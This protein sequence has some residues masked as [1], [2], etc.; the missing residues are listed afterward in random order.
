MTTAPVATMPGVERQSPPWSRRLWPWVAGLA[1][2]FV[3]V[4]ELYLERLF[5]IVTG[6]SGDNFFE[7]LISAPSSK[8]NPDWSHALV[9]PFISAFFIYTKRDEI[10][11]ERPRLYFPGL[12]IL[13][14][15]LFGY[16]FWVTPG[17][18]DMMQG[19]SM[20]VGLFGL[21]LFLLG[22]AVMRH[23]WFPILYLV[24]AVKVAD[25]LWEQIAFEL[26]QIAATGAGIALEFCTL[27]FDFDVT[28]EGSQIHLRFMQNGAPVNAPLNVA[29]AC[30]GLRSL[31]AFVALGV[32]MAF[33][34]ERPWWQRLVM[35]LAAVPI[36][37]GV[38]VGRVT[39]LG[40]LYLVN[41]EYARGDFHTMIGLFMLIPAAGLFYV[42]GWVLDRIFVREEG[43]TDDGSRRP[44][45]A[46]GNPAA[47]AAPVASGEAD[48]KA[49]VAGAAVMLA[50][51]VAATLLAA[52]VYRLMLT[53]PVPALPPGGM[54]ALASNMLIKLGWL[55]VPTAA[56]ATG[57]ALGAWV[58]TRALRQKHAHALVLGAAL[59]AGVYATMF[60]YQ[61]VAAARSGEVFIKQ[62]VPLRNPLMLIPAEVGAWKLHREDPPLPADILQELG[63]DKYISRIYEDTGWPAG[64]PGGLV[65]LHVAYYTGTMDAVPHVPERCFVG[66]GAEPL[67]KDLTTL[68]LSGDYRPDPEVEGGSLHPVKLTRGGKRQPDARLASTSIDATR[69]TFGDPG[70][71]R[72]ENVIYF[73]AANGKFLPTPDHVRFAGFDPK[74]KYQYYCKVEVQ[75]FG[76]SDKEL[77]SQRA[78]SLLS[79]LLPEIMACLPDWVD[80]TAGRWPEGAAAPAE[81]R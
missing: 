20:I 68:S 46:A 72:S 73:F 63:T 53:L 71:M 48:T 25:R 29:E 1:G 77:A 24:F 52:V 69:F 14:A 18:N 31:M 78:A 26:Q 41:P 47:A 43:G 30:S 81:A 74:D 4:H 33:L 23:L 27:I 79:D 62:A 15:G 45:G 55:L 61:G 40:L 50:A 59:V 36:A 10:A 44:N 54:V 80:V 39:V 35:I 9:I 7:L 12:A 11:A 8:L 34:W 38:N 58:L 16:L 37:V 32:A 42:I 5:R 6:A 65:R 19:Y 60:A 2:L 67:D 28:R 76:V 70:G 13:F 21:V 56:V 51:G 75:V 3:L 57:V 66:G 17:R 22:P 49:T 64:Q